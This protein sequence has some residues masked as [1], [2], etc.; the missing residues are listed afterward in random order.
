MNMRFLKENQ[1]LFLLLFIGLTAVFLRL[2]NLNHLGL[3]RD[4]AHNGLDALAVLDG[5]HALF[6]EGN[7]G[8]E[9][10]YIYLTAV[11]QTAVSTHLLSNTPATVRLPAAI[12]GAIATFFVYK[13]AA[14][15]FGRHTGLFAAWLWAVTIW[16]VHLSRIGLRAILFVPLFA[17]TLWLGTLAYRQQSARQW[18]AAGAVYGLAFY[19]YLPIRIT[20][21]LLAI[22][23]AAFIMMDRSRL[24]R[25]RGAGWFLLT[26]AVFT[27]PLFFTLWQTGELLGRS[28]QVSILN[29]AIN[30]G[31]LFGTLW[32]QIG[33]AAG[34]FFW[35]GDDIL[36]HNPA[37]RPVFDWLMLLPFIWGLAYTLKRWRQPAAM[38]TLLW[39][40]VMLT[41]TIFAEDAPH[42]LRSIG[43]LP[44]ILF[45]PAIGLAQVWQVG[46][47][48]GRT[49]LLAA[50]AFSFLWG[51]W[52]Y[53]QY[54]RS[55][56]TAYLFEQAATDMAA[57]INA[58]TGDVFI[59]QRFWDGWPS[60][61]YLTN[62]PVTV[63]DTSTS[64]V[65][66][67]TM[68]E[69]VEAATVYFWPYE[70]YDFIQNAIPPESE[71]TITAGSLARGDLEPEPYVLNGRFSWQPSSSS[72]GAMATFGDFTLVDAHILAQSDSTLSVELAWTGT[73]NATAFVHVLHDGNRIGQSDAPIGSGYLPPDWLHT[74]LVVREQHH[75]PLSQPYDPAHNVV[76]IGL[77]D[78]T[79]ITQLGEPYP[80][81]F[82]P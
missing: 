79:T 76:L 54:G 39:T 64:S 22:F 35:R 46:E 16:P 33:A 65:T 37:N 7:N 53:G 28:G 32:R 44:A 1:I 5:E 41:P 58:D 68:A 14:A 52:D 77:Y 73:G 17:A 2:P 70:N 18:A 56:D 43:I 47:R 25:L 27:A 49:F 78:P 26:T 12:A 40:A 4:E 74:N 34:M 45:F 9:P 72:A 11:L 71:L 42:F 69:P 82:A 6:F 15:W 19:S 48:W 8:R 24:Q 29:S 75:I 36:R 59:D 81:Q 38:M 3:Y 10:L 21:I 23:L 20:P 30:G 57:Q 62:R 80:L 31:D 61:R 50:L 66:T 55:A 51:R 67:K 60:I 63:F 13:L